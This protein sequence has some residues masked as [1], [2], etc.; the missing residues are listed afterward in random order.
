MQK[1]KFEVL[2][3][4]PE[5]T[6]SVLVTSGEDSVIFD[7][8]GRVDDWQKLLESRKLNLRAIYATHGHSDHI[9]AAPELARIYNVPWYMNLRDLPLVLWG[10]QILDFWELP[11]ISDDFVRPNDLHAGKTKILGDIDMEI[12]AAPGHS[13]GGVMFYFPEYKILISGDTIFRDGVGR[14]DLPGGNADELHKTIS[15][16]MARNLPDD[17]YVVHGHG[18][19]SMMKDIKKRYL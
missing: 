9:S 10:N 18:M 3:M 12:I 7:A 15:D 4:E 17:T 14:T 5:F 6:N 1:N 19:D 2:H 13:A 8:W 16:L 11:R